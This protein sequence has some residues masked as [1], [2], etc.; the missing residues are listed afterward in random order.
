MY[1]EVLRSITGIEIWPLVSLA[2]FFAFFVGLL[3]WVWLADK[4]YIDEMSHLP[5]DS[6][7]SSTPNPLNHDTLK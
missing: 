7:Q 5:M 2:I 1:K 3:L 4:D 6:D